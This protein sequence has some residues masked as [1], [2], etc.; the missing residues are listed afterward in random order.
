MNSR[1]RK[2]AVTVLAAPGAARD[3]LL[4]TNEVQ[5][6]PAPCHILAGHR[7]DSSP[8]RERITRHGPWSVHRGTVDGIGCFCSPVLGL[9]L[10]IRKV[11]DIRLWDTLPELAAVAD[12]TDLAGVASI[13][14]SNLLPLSRWYIAADSQVVQALTGMK[15]GSGG[16]TELS[17]EP[18]D[19]CHPIEGLTTRRV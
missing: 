16:G 1:R 3:A 19:L 2:I 8:L 6:A 11:R 17:A 4:G 7:H 15:S 5:F 9:L 13:M 12:G 10:S 14:F 18:H